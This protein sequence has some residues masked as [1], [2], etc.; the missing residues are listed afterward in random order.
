MESVKTE[1]RGHPRGWKD[2]ILEL[3]ILV[4]AY[5]LILGL[6]VPALVTAAGPGCNSLVFA[7]VVGLSAILMLR[8]SLV[9]RCLCLLVLLGALYGMQREIN[10]REAWLNRLHDRRIRELHRQFSESSNQ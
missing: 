8:K 4:G 7:F 1:S 2:V 5:V 9:S 10:I 3:V 6:V